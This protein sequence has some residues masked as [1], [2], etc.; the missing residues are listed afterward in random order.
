MVPSRL[1][2]RSLYLEKS[3]LLKLN[4]KSQIH[5]LPADSYP[6]HWAAPPLQHWSSQGWSNIFI[7]GRMNILAPIGWILTKEDARQQGEE[8]MSTSLILSSTVYCEMRVL[9]EISLDKYCMSSMSSSSMFLCGKLCFSDQHGNNSKF[10]A[11][12]SV[13]L[14]TALTFYNWNQV[15][16]SLSFSYSTL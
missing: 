12:F 8:E 3:I 13:N 16:K 2:V 11:S 6:K 4:V 7:L 9:L 5:L 14:F 15:L 10:L 1:S